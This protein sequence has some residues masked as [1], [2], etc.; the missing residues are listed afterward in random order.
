MD[1]LK[2]GG[3]S[4][5][6]AKNISRVIDIVS[7]RDSRQAVVVVS[8]LGGITNQL[9]EVA[10]LAENGQDS[11]KTLLTEIETRHLDVIKALITVNRQ[12]SV[13]AK[14]KIQLNELEDLLRG[15]SLVGEVSPRTL[16]IVQSFG[17]RL[18]S[19]IIYEAFKERGFDVTHLDARQIIKTD[20]NFN[21]ALVDFDKTNALITQWFSSHKGLHIIPGFIASNAENKTTTL[22]RGG[23]DYTASI[24]AAAL[25]SSILEIWTDV[26]GMMTA[27]PRK[28]PKAF[29]VERVSYSEAMELS[30]FGAKVIYPPTIV[31]AMAKKIPIAIKNTFNPSLFGTLIKDLV[32][33]N[34]S[35]IRG[36]SSID[37]ICLLT[38]EG[39]GLVGVS[40]VA[41]RVFRALAQEKI[42]V[43]LITQGSSEHNITFAVLPK[44]ASKS[45][46]IL[47]KEFA[48]ER[49]LNLVDPIRV[50]KELSIIAVVGEN[51][52]NTPGIS[53]RLFEALGRNGISVVCTAQGASELNISVVIEKY[54]VRK[55]LNAIHEA[56]F[57]DKKKRLNLYV[58]G[59]GTIGKTLLTQINEQMDYLSNQTNIDV[60][61]VGLANSKRMWFN[62]DGISLGN[63][64]EELDLHGSRANLNEFIQKMKDQNMRNAVFVDNTANA[65]VAATYADILDA[66]INVVTPNKI[67]NSGTVKHYLKLQQLAL[68]KNVYFLYE[69]NV[70]AGLPI[71]ST[72]KDMIHSGDKILR[73]EAILS[74]TL[75]YL[76]SSIS[77]E[78]PFS[79]VVREA[80]ELGFTEPDPRLDLNGMDVGRK[81]LI[82]SREIGHQL[83][84]SDVSIQN[85]MSTETQASETMDEFWQNL[86]KYEDGRYA[87]MISKA[88]DAGNCLRYVAT[89]ENGK[90]STEV[91]EIPPSHPFY[92]LEGSDNM[93]KFTSSRYKNNPL[94]VK[95]PGAG[96][97]VTAAGVFADIVRIINTP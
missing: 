44:E 37:D 81:V 7:N 49:K 32:E 75:N 42:N 83:E 78:K 92:T 52:K 63:W 66:N 17:E 80:K 85:L 6:D 79:K 19:Y 48:L 31:P 3:T 65:T 1:V 87:E 90:V 34:T 76:F 50:D 57:L 30:H 86:E 62:E 36:I 59:T 61:L 4:V 60:R 12:S 70:G 22:G 28:V 89:I 84:L 2:F 9:I 67:A 25:N 5:K 71:I 58:V 45:K 26:D 97:E 53:A 46:E 77:E 41:M 20:S 24:L 82:L 43:I 11:Y 18:S 68:K 15:M 51:M 38:V 39:S 8:A 96:A 55:G 21:N 10:T 40:G 16:D 72:L 56:F 73:I 94:T 23:S 95:G 33:D 74:G 64:R 54:H 47:E 88:K 93:I 27:D 69:T 14:V 29:P 13:V 91:K 35:S